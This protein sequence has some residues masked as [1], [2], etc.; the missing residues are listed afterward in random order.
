MTNIAL[1]SVTN[2]TISDPGLEMLRLSV[3]EVS[4]CK[5]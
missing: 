3:I 1:A 4:L 2:T 5:L